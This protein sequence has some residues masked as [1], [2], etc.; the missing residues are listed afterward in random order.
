MYGLRL[1]SSC[2]GLTADQLETYPRQQV[3]IT[4][5]DST[6]ATKGGTPEQRLH[7]PSSNALTRFRAF[8]TARDDV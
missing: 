2:I 5:P 3:S 8:A 6:Y 4:D 7:T 1:V